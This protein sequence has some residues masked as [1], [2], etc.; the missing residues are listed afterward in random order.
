MP[1]EVVVEVADVTRDYGQGATAVHALRGVS[2][3]IHA[4]EVTLLFGPSGSGKTTLLQ[5]IGAL[6]HPSSGQVRLLDQVVADCDEEQLAALRRRHCGFVFQH[7]NLLTALRVWENVAMA[8]DVTD[9]GK[10]LSQHREEAS[11][12]L[13]QLGLAGLDMR[14]PNELSGGQK[15]RVAIAR[16]MLMQPRL[17]LADEP[18]AALDTVSGRRVAAVLNVLAHVRN[19]AVVIVT[20]DRRLIP[21][22]N[23]V[24]TLSDG[25]LVSDQRYTLDSAHVL[26]L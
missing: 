19:C 21:F 12:L 7:Y 10:P 8:H 26:Y 25:K 3:S 9:P 16:A 18:T 2:L 5:V 1:G 4:G 23:R 13:R 11:A 6:L 15:Q 20:H 14:F 24:L 17:L 22:A